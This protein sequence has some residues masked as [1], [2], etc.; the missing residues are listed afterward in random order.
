MYI[1]LSQEA[2]LSHSQR[3]RVQY[4]VYT[5]VCRLIY[6]VH[7]APTLTSNTGAT[8]TFTP[9]ARSTTASSDRSGDF[10]VL[11]DGT[12]NLGA[13]IG[14]FATDSVEKY[15]MGYSKGYF[16]AC[17]AT[18]SLLGLLGW[19]R[20]MVKLGLGIKNCEDAGFNTQSI[21]PIYGVSED[22]RLPSDK[23]FDVYYIQRSEKN[24][25]FKWEMIKM[26]RHTTDSMPL[27]KW[28]RVQSRSRGPVPHHA[29]GELTDPWLGGWKGFVVMTVLHLLCAGA[30]CF[31]ILPFR[32]RAS[33]W[34]WST[35]LATFGLFTSI[36]VGSLAWFWVFIQGQVDLKY[37]RS[38]VGVAYT[39][40]NDKSYFIMVEGTSA[41]Q[42]RAVCIVS[43]MAAIFAMIGYVDDNLSSLI[44]SLV[45]KF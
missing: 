1:N 7:S 31:T 3:L 16:S 15:A 21:R 14:I 39:R 37:V 12:Q 45:L 23:V 32:H 30:T 5:W 44:V 34:S 22:D 40:M 24:N 18:L 42:L 43:F 38:Q 20:T 29:H 6:F 28:A 13:L 26:V 17:V 27:V 19:A 35:Y 8:S 2:M 4:L 36:L 11:A 25:M 33:S 41:T 9:S 10:Q